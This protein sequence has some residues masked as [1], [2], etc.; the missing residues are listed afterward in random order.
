MSN[1]EAEKAYLGCCFADP[2][3]LDRCDVEVEDFG[4]GK[5]QIMY[6]AML[7]MRDR[8]LPPE[9][10]LVLQSELNGT[11][12]SAVL[13]D[14]MLGTEVFLP[15]GKHYADL[16]I[17]ASDRRKFTQ[18]L[19]QAAKV[20]LSGKLAIEE[21]TAI[22]EASISH[23]QRKVTSITEAVG[24]VWQRTEKYQTNPLPDGAVRDLDTGWLDLNR[25][26]GG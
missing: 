15:Y 26:T 5:H 12:D 25:H 22:V 21:A 2:S 24:N 16:I 13:W 19:N 10:F 8:G 7:A 1:P 17:E 23:R 14:Y 9:D 20:G 18:A 4:D 6:D 11:V 3:L